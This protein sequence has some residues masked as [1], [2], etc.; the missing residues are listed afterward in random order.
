MLRLP[1]QKPDNACMHPRMTGV[2]NGIRFGTFLVIGAC[3]FAGASRVLP[4]IHVVPPVASEPIMRQP[5]SASESAVPSREQAGELQDFETRCHVPGVIVCQSF[6]SQDRS[7]PAKYPNSGLYAAWDGAYRGTI[8][9][10]VKASGGGS[11]RFEVPPHS[12]ANASGYWRQSLGRDFGQGST[13]YVQFRQR[14]SPEML[15]NDWG[16]TSWKQVIFHNG[17]QTCTDLSLVT[18]QYYQAGFPIMY[19]SCGARMVAT[20]NGTPPYQLQQG[21]YNCWYGRFNA[22]DCFLYPA[23]EWVAFYY[24]VHVGHWGKPDSSVNAWVAR[25]GQPYRQWIKMPDFVLENEH[26]GNDYDNLTLLTYMTNKDAT[27][28]HPVAYT[29]YDELIV[30]SQ[31]ISAPTH[32]SESK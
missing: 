23:N 13:L 21:D 18:A 1:T 31:P 2:S 17:G 10:T 30:S 8:D 3:L 22:K 4:R 9:T 6:D 7:R 29:W 14:F 28:N 32:S 5:A 12:A 20:N 19:A 24:Q 16:G 26:P 25:D 27:R 11:L 15:K